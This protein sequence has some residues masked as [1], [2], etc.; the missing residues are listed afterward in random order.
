MPITTLLTQIK[1]DTN[2]W[3]SEIHGVS[4]WVRVMEN[5]LRIGRENGANLEVVKYFSYLHDC[6]R[7]NEGE[8]PLHGPRAAAY[9]RHHRQLINLD[10]TQF[11]VLVIACSGHT[12]AMPNCKAGSNP[13]LAACW[14][15]DRLD[16][17]RVGLK[18]DP[19]YLFSDMG[20]RSIQYDHDL[21]DD[22]WGL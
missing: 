13:T 7:L 10:E 15:G 8:D 19:S 5:G 17:P 1:R 2:I 20:K 12:F 16:L 11:R 14:D 4:H 6:S 18:P 9:A 3:R 21:L 22:D